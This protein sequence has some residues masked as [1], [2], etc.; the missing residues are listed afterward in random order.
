[1]I[2]AQVGSRDRSS[3]RG[4]A[5]GAVTLWESSGGTR[6][7]LLNDEERAQ[8]ALIASVVRLKKNALVYLT[9]HQAEAVFVIITGVV[10]AEFKRISVR[11]PTEVSPFGTIAGAITS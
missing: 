5:I 7:Q 8:L 4:P 11:P 6:A 9:G 2:G 3:G 10:T 1:M